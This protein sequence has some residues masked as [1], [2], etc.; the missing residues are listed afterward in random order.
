MASMAA[1]V[2]RRVEVRLADVVPEAVRWL[3]RL[4]LPMGKLV[5]L[6]GDPS[7]GKSTLALDMA[8]RITTGRP[9]PG[10]E[11]AACP[12][13]AVILMSAEDGLADTIRPRLDAAGA[14]TTKVHA[15]T[16]IEVEING[17]VVTR[18]PAI[19][20]DLDQL[21]QSIIEHGAVLVVID[22]LMAYLSSETNSYQ[23]QA[24]RR[25]LAPVALLAERTRCCIIVLRHL[26]KPSSGGGRSQAIYAG[27]GS[28]AIVGAARVGLL[29]A[30]DPD[31]AEIPDENDRR[32][33]LAV[34]K[35][36]LAPKARSQ[37]YRIVGEGTSSRI[38]WLGDV[39]HH[40]DDL[41]DVTRHDDD[42]EARAEFLAGLLADGSVEVSRVERDAQAQGWT[43]RQ[44]RPVLKRLGGDSRRVGYGSDGY[45]IWCLDCGD[46]SAI[47]DAPPIDDASQEWASMDR[48]V[49]YDAFP[50]AEVIEEEQF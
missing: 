29:A 28:I 40:A 5:V 20:D 49:I 24:V 35:N 16:A 11:F 44:L 21:E 32:R 18:A 1:T 15:I 4:W 36:N 22:V 3:W 6:D 43:L 12:P 8:A 34:E 23:D 7:T 25:A 42:R 47:D 38:E 13:S 14:D 30:F 17:E 41:V 2:V 19:P 45:W 50:G 31:D 48:R 33:V 39:H 26:R 46:P 27:G 10:E 37:S 9:F